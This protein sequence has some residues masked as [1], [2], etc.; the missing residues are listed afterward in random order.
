MRR[1]RATN[2][3]IDR[4]PAVVRPIVG[5]LVLAGGVKVIDVLWT[6]VSGR[7]PPSDGVADDDTGPRTVRDRVVYALLLGGMMRLAERAGLA[8]MGRR[9]AG[10]RS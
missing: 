9:R 6:R 3:M 1:N 2:R 7:R 8:S 10:R 5:G 4:V